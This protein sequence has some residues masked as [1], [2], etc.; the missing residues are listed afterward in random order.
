LPILAVILAPITPSVLVDDWWKDHFGGSGAV[1]I[2]RLF[3]H[4]PFLATQLHTAPAAAAT[5]D[6]NLRPS[7]DHSEGIELVAGTV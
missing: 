6:L 5:E 2:Q 4:E 3:K 7:R 1:E